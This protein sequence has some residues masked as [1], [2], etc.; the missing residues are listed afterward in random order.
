MYTQKNPAVL[1]RTTGTKSKRAVSYS[2][3]LHCSTIGAGGW[4]EVEPRCSSHPKWR[5][6][7]TQRQDTDV[8]SMNRNHMRQVSGN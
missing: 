5:T 8:R 4:E 1:W 6:R 7:H 3:A 2:P